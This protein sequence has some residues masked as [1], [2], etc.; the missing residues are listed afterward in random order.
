MPT[1]YTS[2]LGLALPATGELS[3]TWGS[4]VNDFI[5]QYL[6]SSVEGTQ[7]I[8]GSQTAVTLSVANGTSLSQAGS[9]A[10]GS[11]Q[12]AIINCTGNPASLLTVTAPASSRQYIVINATSTSQSVK[13]VGVGP[14]TGVTL[15]SGEKTIVAWNG[16]DFVKVASPGDIVGPASSTDNAITRFDGTTGKL[17]Q[18]SSVT[19]SDAGAVVAP[20]AGSVIPFYFDNQAAF[21]SANTYHGAVAHSHADGA[22]YFAHGGVWTRLLQD[23]GALGTPS[24]GT[25]TN[26][27]GLPL[28]TGV[29]GTLPVANGG[30][31]LSSGTSGGILAFTASGTIASSGVLAA[32][33]IVIGGGAGVAPSTSSLLSVAAAVTTGNYIRSIGY[34]DTVTAL[35]NT[36]TA[37]NLDITSGGVF[38]ATLTGNATITLRYPVAT[39]SSSFTLILTNDGT[40][41]RTVAYAGGSFKF[42]GGAASLSR[43]TTANAVDIW[44]FFTPD[45]GTT[46]YGNIA[47]KDVKA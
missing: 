45:G 20:Q 14:T 12:F 31:G 11:A 21:P 28:S 39:G 5:T 9:S 22:M 41:G 43:T 44:V 37:I 40:A 16:S 13:I 24:S 35:G 25:A 17:L 32:N 38:T 2:L 33:T 30:T 3:G 4:T 1:T 26:L 34:A 7:T 47:M 29:T 46:Y 42:P 27:T 10:T 36:G 8:S 6:D 15:V 23:G 19:I 18:N